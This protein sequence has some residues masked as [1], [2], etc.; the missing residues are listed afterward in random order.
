M[1][2]KYYEAQ[3]KICELPVDVK[4]KEYSMEKLEYIEKKEAVIYLFSTEDVNIFYM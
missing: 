4:N 3:V 2:T 1:N